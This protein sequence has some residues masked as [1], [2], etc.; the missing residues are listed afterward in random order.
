MTEDGAN[1]ADDERRSLPG[2]VHSP[3]YRSQ[4]ETIY[5]SALDVSTERFRFDVQFF[6]NSNTIFTHRGRMRARRHGDQYAEPR[7]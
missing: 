1:Q 6:G 7:A 5:L 4:I 3:D 2:Q